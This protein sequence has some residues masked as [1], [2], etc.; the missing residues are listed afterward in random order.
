M[1]IDLFELPIPDWGL[2]CPTCDY[3]LR[4]LPSHRC[5]ECGTRLDM[6]K[7]VQTWTRLR[8][9]RF[10]GAESPFPDLGLSC[11]ACGQ[12]LAGAERAAC[13]GCKQAFDARLLRPAKTWFS[14]EPEMHRPLPVQMVESILVAEQVPCMVR[15]GRSAFGVAWWQLMVPSEFYFEFL[16]LIRRARQQIESERARNHDRRWQ[17]AHCNESNPDGFEVCWNCQTARD[18]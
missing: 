5:P 1:Q 9:P 10:T 12:P 2:S 18:R 15:E 11:A 13:P 6:A 16:W 17:C 8:A 4:G 7:L 14:V 3:L